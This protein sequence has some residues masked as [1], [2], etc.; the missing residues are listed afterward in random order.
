M[1]Y[2]VSF[3]VPAR[4]LGKSDIRFIVRTE[5]GV[6]GTLRVSKGALVWFPKKTNYGHKVPWQSFA[7]IAAE[8]FPQSEYRSG[9]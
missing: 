9:T 8:Q 7:K 2:E 1:A 4:P 6:L 5:S 3:D